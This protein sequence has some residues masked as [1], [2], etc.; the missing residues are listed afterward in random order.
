M[1]ADE[2]GCGRDCKEVPPVVGPPGKH[3]HVNTSLKCPHD[4][5]QV[6]AESQPDISESF[7]VEAVPTYIILKA[8]GSSMER[9]RMLIGAS[10][11]AHSTQQNS[12]R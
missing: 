10:S 9:D 11:G 2:R 3:P 6:D 7:E 5:G 12:W 4:V 1:Q 8:S